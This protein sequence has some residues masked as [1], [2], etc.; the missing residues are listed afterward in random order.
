MNDSGTSILREGLRERC[1]FCW[2]EQLFRRIVSKMDCAK[3]T[4]VVTV[5]RQNSKFFP[6]RWKARA[7]KHTVVSWSFGEKAS[8]V[9]AVEELWMSVSLLVDLK[10]AMNFRSESV[11][12]VWSFV[13]GA[14]ICGVNSSLQ[15]QSSDG[16]ASIPRVF[17]IKAN[18]ATFVLLFDFILETPGLHRPEAVRLGF[19]NLLSCVCLRYPF[20]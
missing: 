19:G 2:M 5:C 11:G 9:A 6:F 14:K 17:V 8:G 7:G 3:Q 13:L 1:Y 10:C 4:W 20:K 18:L 16:K 15:I 12:T